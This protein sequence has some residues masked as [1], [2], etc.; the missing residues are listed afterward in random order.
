MTI[1]NAEPLRPFLPL[2]V[3]VIGILSVLLTDII[4]SAIERATAEI[5]E[6]LGKGERE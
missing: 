5:V 6:A 4:W 3:V 1:D 2:L